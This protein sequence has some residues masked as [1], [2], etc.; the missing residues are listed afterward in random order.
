MTTPAEDTWVEVEGAIVPAPAPAPDTV[1]LPRVDV[2]ATS[3]RE[4]PRPGDTYE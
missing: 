4:V 3:V 2:E 1:D